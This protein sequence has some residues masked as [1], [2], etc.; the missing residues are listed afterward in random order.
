MSV[1][2]SAWATLPQLHPL[3]WLERLQRLAAKCAFLPDCLCVQRTREG[4]CPSHGGAE[5]IRTKPRLS[6]ISTSKQNN[7]RTP[8]Q[9]VQECVGDSCRVASDQA[10]GIHRHRIQSL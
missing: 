5:A 9:H 8:S 4:Q 1:A 7:A 6:S 3:W 2:F 10:H